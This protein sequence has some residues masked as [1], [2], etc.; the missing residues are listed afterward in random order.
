MTNTFN[1][2]DNDLFFLVDWALLS[3]WSNELK[4]DMVLLVMEFDNDRDED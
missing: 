1:S 2:M 4:H 3:Y